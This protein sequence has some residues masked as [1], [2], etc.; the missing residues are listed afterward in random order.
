MPMKLLDSVFLICYRWQRFLLMWQKAVKQK[1]KV[2]CTS[3]LSVVRPFLQPPCWCTIVKRFMA[4]REYM[5]AM[6]AIKP[7]SGQHISR[8][9]VI[10]VECSVNFCFCFG[11]FAVL[12]ESI[13][14]P[15]S[16]RKFGGV[17]GVYLRKGVEAIMYAQIENSLL[18]HGEAFNA[19]IDYRMKNLK[20]CHA[21][22]SARKRFHLL[23]LIMY[24]ITAN[25]DFQISFWH[26]RK[27]S[28]VH[29]AVWLLN[30]L[31][32]EHKWYLQ[33]KHLF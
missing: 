13:L 26:H 16:K 3:V 32:C 7:L 33:R 28:A 4:R 2:V 27:L 18:E 29:S 20:Y 22:N 1:K 11:L 5:F 17:R 8:Y 23:Y 14:L 15:L 6:S 31:S 30:A 9:L 10:I 21:N 25:P 12:V 19:C 24:I